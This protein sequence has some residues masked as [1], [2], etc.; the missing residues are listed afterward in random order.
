MDAKEISLNEQEVKPVVDL[1]NDYLANYH[2]HYQKLRGCHWNIKGSNFFTLHV[3]FEELYT[4]AQTTIDEIAE[5]VL[6]LGKPPHSR[7]AD[8]I[9]ESRIKEIDTIGMQDM[10]MIDAILDDMSKL[11]EMER[12]LLEATDEAGDEGTNDMVN[13]F[14]Q[15][16]EKN[17]WM[18]RSFADK[19]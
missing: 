12:E 13:R 4:E 16:K 11:I 15:F 5:R 19:K 14:M 7:F 17:T 2:I 6:T 1:L 8:Y 18:L 3:K 9:N 10:A